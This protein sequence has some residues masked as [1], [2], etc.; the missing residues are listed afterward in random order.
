MLGDH[1]AHD[2]KIEFPFFVSVSQVGILLSSEMLFVL[3][4]QPHLMRVLQD[5]WSP[6]KAQKLG[7]YRT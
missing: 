4:L 1:M 5:V 2:V 3:I 6:W 7:A